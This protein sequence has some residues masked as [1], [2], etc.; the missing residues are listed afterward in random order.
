MD[1]DR[2]LAASVINGERG[3]GIHYLALFLLSAGRSD[4]GKVLNDFFRVFCL[5]GT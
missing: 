2:V 5:A 1:D 3:L 4:Q